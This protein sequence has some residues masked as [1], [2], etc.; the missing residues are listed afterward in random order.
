MTGFDTSSFRSQSTPLP[1]TSQASEQDDRA[2]IRNRFLALLGHI[3]LVVVCLSGVI[4]NSWNNGFLPSLVPFTIQSNLLLAAYASYAAWLILSEKSEPA[5]A[6]AGAVTLYIS[7]TGLVYN[8]LLARVSIL[9]S[10]S[11]SNILL[12]FV[13]PIVAVFNWILL[14][15]HGR[16]RWRHALFWLSYILGYL[17]FCLIRGPLV[18][19]GSRYPYF[20]VNVDRIGYGG[21]ALNA[22]LYGG[23][24][25]LLGILLVF[26]DRLLSQARHRVPDTSS[27]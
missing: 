19:S 7:I 9:A 15:A 23:A 14:T 3:I 26:F 4:I 20:F 22:F 2:F 11:I 27:S 12:H 24:F 21:V 10:G 8:L 18:T 5:P 17:V 1:T 25:W 6:L 13:A 16:L